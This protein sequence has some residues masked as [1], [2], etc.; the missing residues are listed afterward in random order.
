MQWYPEICIDFNDH[1][2]PK[3]SEKNWRVKFERKT[4]ILRIAQK[5]QGYAQ[6][7]QQEGW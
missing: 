5:I 2:A 6:K 1:F 7:D 4:N 3:I